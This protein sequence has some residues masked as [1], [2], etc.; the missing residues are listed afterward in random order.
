MKRDTDGS[1]YSVFKT[2]FK[3]VHPLML[4]ENFLAK[5]TT[6]LKGISLHVCYL[7][8]NP[9]PYKQSLK[10]PR[11]NRAKDRPWFLSNHHFLK[12]SITATSEY[13]CMAARSS[14][15]PWQKLEFLSFTL[16]GYDYFP[17]QIV[18]GWN[19]SSSTCVLSFTFHCGLY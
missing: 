1:K 2:V 18:S 9:Q 7:R 8:K 19:L 5:V 3:K 12:V 10:K 6:I 14:K 16:R 17:S 4:S 15:Y 11:K 13:S